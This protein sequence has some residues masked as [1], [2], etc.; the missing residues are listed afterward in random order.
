MATGKAATSQTC[1]LAQMGSDPP[2]GPGPS[3]DSARDTTTRSEE[4]QWHRSSSPG[5]KPVLRIHRKQEPGPSGLPTLLSQCLR[6]TKSP[7]DKA[8]RHMLKREPSSDPSFAPGSK[9]QGQRT[10]F[11]SPARKQ[12]PPLLQPQ[13][14]VR[15]PRGLLP[16]QAHTKPRSSC[17]LSPISL[18]VRATTPV[19]ISKDPRTGP[20]I[21]R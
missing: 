11:T 19:R 9:A 20:I 2:G 15:V 16:S 13:R 21:C 1:S 6:F 14:L 4:Q 17:L 3:R 8:L 10:V 12:T 5:P 18:L 7:K